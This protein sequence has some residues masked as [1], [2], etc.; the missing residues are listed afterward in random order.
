MLETV[1]EYALEQLE[2]SGEGAAVQARHAA[3]D[4]A[5]EE[6]WAT[7]EREPGE[8]HD[9]GPRQVRAPLGGPTSTPTESPLTLGQVPG[10]RLEQRERETENVRAA[11]RWFE[12]VGTA[13]PGL[14]L[15]LAYSP[16]WLY[17]GHFTD[18]RDSLET[19]LAAGGA[20]P[21][22][23]RA[24]ALG[25]AGHLAHVQGDYARAT[26]RGEAAVAVWREVGDAVGLHSALTAL[27]LAYG[28]RGET[29]RAAALIEESLALARAAGYPAG[30]SRCL[31]DLSHVARAE[32][33]VPRA[34]ALLERSIAVGEA[35]AAGPYHPWRSAACLGRLEFLQ[36]ESGAAAARLRRCL[37]QAQGGGWTFNLADC[38]E[39]AA[40]ARAA[41]P[42]GGAERARWAARVFGAAAALR[43]ETGEVRY[44]AERAAYEQDVAATRTWLGETA[45]VAG[46]AE[47]E[48]MSPE[49]AVAD[50]LEAAPAPADAATSP[51]ARSP[52]PAPARTTPRAS[53]APAAGS[54]RGP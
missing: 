24:W 26:A 40:A 35:E 11:L 2:R 8:G 16:I 7:S 41:G 3:Y 43:R 52:P 9:R 15:A 30:V 54:A 36:G 51:P 48:A 53:V 20:A 23:L 47:G 4:L 34:R 10:A 49:Q 42:P 38:L 39:W 25:W 50:A 29:A 32:G 14:R 45:F 37:A 19:L 18:L 44:P 31:R 22:D 33:D 17:R 27:G 1:R 46:W 5:L 21:A 6:P 13:G 28:M 12:A